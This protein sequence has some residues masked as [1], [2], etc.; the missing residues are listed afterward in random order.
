M[1]L[2]KTAVWLFLLAGALYTIAGLRDIFAPGFL[3]MSP[4]VPS[5]GGIV[6]QFLLA[7][8]FLAMAALT[9]NTKNQVG[10][11]KK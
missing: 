9:N 5:R 4:Q 6:M 7:G 1:K 3:N 2:K 11:D 10:A 8:V